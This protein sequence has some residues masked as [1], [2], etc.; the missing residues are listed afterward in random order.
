MSCYAGYRLTGNESLSQSVAL[1]TALD[2]A[3]DA[4]HVACAP[5]TVILNAVVLFIGIRRID[6][7]LRLNQ[8]YVISMTLSDPTFGVV[9]LSTKLVTDCFPQWFCRIYYVFTWASQLL[10]VTSLLLLNVDKFISLHYPLKYQQIV[11]KEL[12]I[13]LTCITWC[14][15]ISYPSI[16]FLGPMTNFS[17]IFIKPVIND[18]VRTVTTCHVGVNP[19]YYLI[20]L[21]GFYVFPTLLSLAISVYIF[22][23]A[24][25]IANPAISGVSGSRNRRAG[26]NVQQKM[27]K[28]ILFVFSSTTWTALTY[29]PYRIVFCAAQFC[30]LSC[31]TMQCKQRCH[32]SAVLTLGYVFWFLLPLGCVGNP[33]ITVVTQRI[34]RMQLINLGRDLLIDRLRCPAKLLPCL[35]T[36]D[37]FHRNDTMGSMRDETSGMT[38]RLRGTSR[39]RPSMARNPRSPR[40]N[41][42]ENEV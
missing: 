6:T 32:P 11:T 19:T 41:V 26:K 28:R 1:D 25:H 36:A 2:F 38:I 18:T 7:S 33:I 29:L 24:Q 16:V 21:T 17:S 22:W 42:A 8:Y 35:K 10:S 20:M 40:N 31:S 12:V 30:S 23:I 34:Y 13:T 4:F 39:K 5:L 3:L 9:Y 37:P 14:L 15:S 27:V